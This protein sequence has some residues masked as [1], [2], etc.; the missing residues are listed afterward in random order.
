MNKP[1]STVVVTIDV[2][3]V[4]AVPPGEM[5]AIFDRLVLAPC[6]GLGYATQEPGGLNLT[7]TLPPEGPADSALRRVGAACAEFDSQTTP[8]K[9]RALIHYGTVFRNEGTGGRITYLGSAIRAAQTSLRRI[10]ATSG[11]FASKDFTTHVTNFKAG[12]FGM[13]I[14]AGPEDARP[15]RFEDRRKSGGGEVPGSDPQ[16]QIT[17]KKRLAEEIGPFAGPLVDNTKHST[18][19]AKE[20]VAA[21]SH[22]IDNPESRQRFEVEM[23]AY[24]KART[25]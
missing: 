20:L 14:H 15:V 3:G 10:A 21:L 11:I 6:A 12:T 5:K 17:L 1:V 2:P 8:V 22:E 13:E 24:I 9:T 7:L 25:R 19:S 4:P 23:L 18:M 16:F